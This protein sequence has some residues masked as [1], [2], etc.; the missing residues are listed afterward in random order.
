LVLRVVS[1]RELEAPEDET[2]FSALL[3][4][5]PPRLRVSSGKPPSPQKL[6]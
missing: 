1:L 4:V 6:G 3:R 5:F 2:L